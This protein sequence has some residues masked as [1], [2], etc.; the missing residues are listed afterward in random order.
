MLPVVEI[1]LE[2][3]AQIAD[4]ERTRP[5]WIEKPARPALQ[6]ADLARERNHL[7]QV[8]IERLRTRDE[9]LRDL[10]PVERA[11]RLGCRDVVA[12]SSASSRSSRRRESS[13]STS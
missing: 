4:A 9:A 5:A 13:S 10:V 12:H 11:E 3:L 6:L 8:R 7:G 1:R 2:R